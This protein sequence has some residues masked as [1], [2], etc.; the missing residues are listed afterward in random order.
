MLIA[1]LRAEQHCGANPVAIAEK[2]FVIFR[3]ETGSLTFDIVEVFVTESQVSRF[4]QLTLHIIQDCPL[5]SE[6]GELLCRLADRAISIPD[7]QIAGGRIVHIGHIFFVHVPGLGGDVPILV[8]LVIPGE[9]PTLQVVISILA[10]VQRIH[11]AVEIV[12]TRSP[13]VTQASI[14]RRLGVR[15]TNPGSHIIA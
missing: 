3:L 6:T 13:C 15:F 10:A 1:K 12:L 8:E 4:S 2:A 5:G 7:Q 9:I 11:A 14:E